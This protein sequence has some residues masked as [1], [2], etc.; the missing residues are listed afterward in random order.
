MVLYFNFFNRRNNLKFKENF[1]FSPM[2]R[3]IYISYCDHYLN[4][5]L[6]SKLEFN[7]QGLVCNEYV[8][9]ADFESIRK[10]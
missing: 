6:N 5:G 8:S 4:W 10:F 3:Y 9:G 7:L 2:F 1:T